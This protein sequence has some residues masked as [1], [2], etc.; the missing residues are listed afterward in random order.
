[1]TKTDHIRVETSLCTVPDLNGV[2]FNDAEAIFRNATNKFTGTVQRD[3]GAPNGNFTITA[4]DL[5]ATSLAPCTS[6][7]KVTRP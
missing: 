2:K 6:N 3:T 7:I 5:T 4:Q 1:V